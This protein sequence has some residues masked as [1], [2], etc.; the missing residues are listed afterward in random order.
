MRSF[1][2]P[3]NAIVIG[4]WSG[5]LKENESVFHMVAGRKNKML[6]KI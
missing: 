2:T 3:Q 6:E 5:P 1:L 4:V